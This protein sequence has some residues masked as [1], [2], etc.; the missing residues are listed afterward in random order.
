MQAASPHRGKRPGDHCERD[1]CAGR[2]RVYAT[3]PNF[4]LMVRTRYLCCDTCRDCPAGNK[5][6]IPLEYA[7]SRATGSTN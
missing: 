4:M 1:G 3:R 6:V 7:P 2:L 5:W